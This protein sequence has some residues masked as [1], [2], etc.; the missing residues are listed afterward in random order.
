MRR[1]IAL[2]HAQASTIAKQGQQTADVRF[3]TVMISVSYVHVRVLNG[4]CYNTV[5]ISVSSDQGSVLTFLHVLT[6]NFHQW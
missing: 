2:T 5:T 4:G 6:Y 3:N 1:L